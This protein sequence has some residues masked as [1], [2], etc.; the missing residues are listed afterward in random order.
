MHDFALRNFLLKSDLKRPRKF[1]GQ[2]SQ[3]N[4]SN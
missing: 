3:E 4:K 2:N 1:L